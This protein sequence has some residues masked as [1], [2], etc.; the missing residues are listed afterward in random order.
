M[1]DELGGKIMNRLATLRFKSYSYL[2]GNNDKDKKAKGIR[3][4]WRKKKT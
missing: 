1:K 2:T 4:M 3:K